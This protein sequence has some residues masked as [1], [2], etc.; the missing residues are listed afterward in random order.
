[1]TI[2]IAR[3]LQDQLDDAKS[4]QLYNEFADELQSVQLDYLSKS[5]PAAVMTVGKRPRHR[6]AYLCL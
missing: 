2:I 4:K 1:M 6:K 3:Q 5:G